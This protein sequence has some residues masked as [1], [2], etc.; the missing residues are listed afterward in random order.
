MQKKK[1]TALYWVGLAVFLALL[2]SYAACFACGLIEFRSPEQIAADELAAWE[3]ET[4]GQRGYTGAVVAVRTAA[5][6]KDPQMLEEVYVVWQATTYYYQLNFYDGKLYYQY[7][8]GADEGKEI[9]ETLYEGKKSGIMAN[10]V[11][12][13]L[14]FGSDDPAPTATFD[15]DALDLIRKDAEV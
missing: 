10:H 3:A 13:N 7:Q 8:L 15:G 2:L 6:E 1:H 4:R 12:T 9:S 14:Y 5:E 11:S